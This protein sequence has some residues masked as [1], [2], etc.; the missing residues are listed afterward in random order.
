ML[1]R[2]ETLLRRL[3][4]KREA[5]PELTEYPTCGGAMVNEAVD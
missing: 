5:L 1:P 2:I 3:P 4:G